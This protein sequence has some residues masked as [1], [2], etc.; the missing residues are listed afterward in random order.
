MEV[1]SFDEFSKLLDEVADALP[2]EIFKNLNGGISLMPE[3]LTH[4]DEEGLF[5]L[6]QYHAGGYLGRYI[7][8][9]YG[10]FM[11]LYGGRTRARLKLEIDR[12]L[13]HE[14]LHHLESM[15]GEKELEIKDAI[16]LARYKGRRL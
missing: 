12:V 2:P 14:F 13:R 5:I 15:A 4:P 10:S 1:L 3:A 16:D 9:H 7:T 11:E 8:L 6:G